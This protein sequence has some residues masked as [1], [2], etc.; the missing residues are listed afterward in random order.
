MKKISYITHS[1]INHEQQDQVHVLKKVY[2]DSILS[3]KLRL[4]LDN[5]HFSVILEGSGL[6]LYIWQFLDISAAPPALVQTDRQT[7]IHTLMSIH[8]TLSSQG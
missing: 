7:H 1:L 5:L 8:Y 3:L 6:Y 2:F 4:R